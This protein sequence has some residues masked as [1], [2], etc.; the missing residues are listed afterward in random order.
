MRGF[1]AAFGRLCVETYYPHLITERLEP[2]A[3]GRLCVETCPNAG[4]CNSGGAAAFGRLCVETQN[5]TAAR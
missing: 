1:A 2:A 3:F 4:Y 5:Q